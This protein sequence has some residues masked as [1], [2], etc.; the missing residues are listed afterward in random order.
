MSQEYTTF[1][2]LNKKRFYRSYNEFAKS[3]TFKKDFRTFIMILHNFFDEQISRNSNRLRMKELSNL[4]MF[5]WFLEDRIPSVFPARFVIENKSIILRSN[6]LTNR[7]YFEPLLLLMDKSVL[8]K[9]E[10]V[11]TM[12]F[13][14]ICSSHTILL[15]SEDIDKIN[16]EKFQNY[17]CATV[18]ILLSH[19]SKFK[20]NIRPYIIESYLSLIAPLYTPLVANKSQ[21]KRV[22]TVL[23]G[24]WTIFELLLAAVNSDRS[25]ISLDQL[26]EILLT[27]EEKLI[28][29]SQFNSIRKKIIKLFPEIDSGEVNPFENEEKVEFTI[30]EGTLHP[31]VKLFSKKIKNRYYIPKPLCPFIGI[32]C[33]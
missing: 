26:I 8:E 15:L 1:L 12:L 16:P 30:S 4:D 19:Q 25:L 29:S 21:I 20:I 6:R 28:K 14:N 2:D 27:I 11:E 5:F 18:F 24:N 13:L 9:R 23:N 32:D 3:R 10:F 33:Y 17:I 7:L 22:E 31:L